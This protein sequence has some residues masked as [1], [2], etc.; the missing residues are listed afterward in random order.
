MLL[1]LV[2]I[3]FTLSAGET[4]PEATVVSKFVA[5]PTME[6]PC[7]LSDDIALINMDGQPVPK[8]TLDQTD[9]IGVSI[10]ET[11]FNAVLSCN[12]Y[13]CTFLLNGVHLVRNS[14]PNYSSTLAVL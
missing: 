5:T 4:T 14:S 8:V 7:W 3:S 6:G 2:K 12:L 10:S 1:I 11:L 9:L 13:S